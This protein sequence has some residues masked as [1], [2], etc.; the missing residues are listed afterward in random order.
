MNRFENKVV[1]VT[2]AARGQG[3]SHA[4]RFAQ[5]GASVIALDLCAGI[6]TVP[7]PLA[8]AGDLAETRTLLESA[9]GGRVWTGAADVRDEDS[10]DAAMAKAVAEVGPIDIVIPNAGIVSFGT[11]DALTV[12]QWRDVIDVDLTGVWLTSKAALRHMPGAGAIV[13]TASA[14]GIR[15]H[16][17]TAH[18]SAAKA[19]VIALSAAMAAEL[20]PRGIR[21]NCVCPTTVS[22][23]MF[24]NP[25]M[26]SLFCPDIESPTVDDVRPRAADL[27]LLPTPWI[28]ASDVSSMIAYLASDEA[29]FVTGAV[30]PVDAGLLVK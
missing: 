12:P 11:V 2:G 13:M 15:P 26:F 18:Y 25:A 7:Y 9:G 4:L 1:L 23:P 16:P 8:S 14:A 10:L 5:E 20:A 22:S 6:D 24:M 27:N 29:R 21:V 17:N 3:R 30:V 28:D 19:G